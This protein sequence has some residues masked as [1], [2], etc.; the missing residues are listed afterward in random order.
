[1]KAVPD[2]NDTLRS[3][4]PVLCLIG[5]AAHPNTTEAKL[6]D[7]WQKGKS[8]ARPTLQMRLSRSGSRKLMQMICGM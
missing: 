2:I 7:H 4:G 3:Q 1:M 5:L 8:R 6:K